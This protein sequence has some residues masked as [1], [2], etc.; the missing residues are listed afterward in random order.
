MTQV[1]LRN[2]SRQKKPAR[3]QPVHATIASDRMKQSAPEV[4]ESASSWLADPE[5]EV[6]CSGAIERPEPLRTTQYSEFDCTTTSRIAERSKEIV[7]KLERLVYLAISVISPPGMLFT[8][9]VTVE[10]S[11]GV[12]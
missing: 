3:N 12:R 11:V 9:T 10:E 8:V 1:G 4:A 5:S 6:H 2:A 7:L